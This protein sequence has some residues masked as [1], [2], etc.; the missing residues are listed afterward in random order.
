MFG[1][2]DQTT[3]MR[4]HRWEEGK[5]Y[6]EPMLEVILEITPNSVSKCMNSVLRYLHIHVKGSRMNERNMKLPLG[7]HCSKN[8]HRQDP[9]LDAKTAGKS[10]RRI[11]AVFTYPLPI[12]CLFITNG[13]M[14][15]WPWRHQ[16]DPTSPRW[17]SSGMR[18]IDSMSP[19]PDMLNWGEPSSTSA[20]QRAQVQSQ[21]K[22]S[23][24]PK[25]EDTHRQM[26][27]TLSL[28]F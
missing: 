27:S 16:E 28:F 8:L 20:S 26:T 25:P 1:Y 7:Q 4:D 3:T 19:W 2:Q 18:H 17:S 9:S 14:V 22:T 21:E 15:S 11:T 5:G 12:R 23:D 6:P 24:K 10:L 13:K